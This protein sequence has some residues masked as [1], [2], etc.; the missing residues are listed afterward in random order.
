MSDKEIRD[1]TV[2]EVKKFQANE[3]NSDQGLCD[4]KLGVN[5]GYEKCL[6]CNDNLECPGHFGRIELAKPVFHIG[7]IET[8]AKIL[9][10]ICW[11]C[12]HLKYPVESKYKE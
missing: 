1:W 3:I 2:E 9:K 12:G 6:T 7:Y 4:Q 10:C 8:V 11:K 5:N